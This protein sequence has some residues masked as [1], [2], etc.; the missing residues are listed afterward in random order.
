[1]SV[2]NSRPDRATVTTEVLADSLPHSTSPVRA[3]STL[4]RGSVPER[5]I[6]TPASSWTTRFCTPCGSAVAQRTEPSAR[7]QARTA[8]SLVGLL[9]P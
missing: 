4:I 5:A 3:S 1:M 9:T 7:S 6:S 2:V 8:D